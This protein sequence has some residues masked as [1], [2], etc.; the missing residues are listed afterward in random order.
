MT[1]P[2]A[3]DQTL[4]I[5]NL[6]DKISTEEMRRELYYLFSSV[7]P[8]VKI[9]YHKGIKTRGQAWISFVTNDGAKLAKQTLQGFN[10][11][12]KPIQI[13]YANQPSK[14][15]VEFNEAKKAGTANLAD[16]VPAAPEPEKTSILKVSGIPPKFPE[17]GLR[18][19]FKQIQ[20]LKSI[21]IDTSTHVAIVTYETPQQ[22]T[23]A[24]D[25]FQ[26]YCITDQYFLHIEYVSSP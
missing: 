14:A 11:L 23:E 18:L 4:W 2:S 10:L 17:L 21:N 6:N 26:N 8:I 15:I 13:Q 1:F 12:G 5:K 20:G 22:A 9:E 3:E 25:K 16:I 7:S 24:V 19:I